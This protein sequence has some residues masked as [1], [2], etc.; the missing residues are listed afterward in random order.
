MILISRLKRLFAH[1]KATTKPWEFLVGTSLVTWTIFH[2]IRG[3][4]VGDLSLFQLTAAL[5][6]VGVVVYL[7]RRK[8]KAK[9]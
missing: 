2:G 4:K 3:T 9:Q 1:L 8:K 7:R 6:V 5:A